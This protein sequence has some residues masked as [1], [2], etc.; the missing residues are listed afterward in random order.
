MT[1]EEGEKD[2]KSGLEALEEDPISSSSHTITSSPS[3]PSSSSSFSSFSS[4]SST[5]PAA[6]WG[7]DND[8]DTCTRPNSS[9]YRSTG[10]RGNE[11]VGERAGPE[12]EDECRAA[13]AAKVE[14]LQLGMLVQ[15]GE[16]A[17]EGGGIRGG[18]NEREDG[19]WEE[20]Q[21][22][23]DVDS[24]APLS[25]SSVLPSASAVKSASEPGLHTRRHADGS[26]ASVL[27]VIFS[28][29]LSPPSHTPRLVLHQHDW[30]VPP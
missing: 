21:L 17:A 23:Q 9:S 20:R 6:T 29:F 18:E 12:K 5:S 13:L 2:E 30:L 1:K 3:S 24:V 4:P 8:T 11:D 16:G 19:I 25:S 27:Q 22:Q 14:R 15:A 26:F 10:R 28:S 7:N